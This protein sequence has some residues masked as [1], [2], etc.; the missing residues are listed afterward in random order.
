NSIREKEQMEQ[1]EPLEIIGTGSFGLIRKVRRKT[2]GKILARKEIDYRRMNEK[3]RNQLSAEFSILCE[4]D[5]PNIVRYYGR[6]V[7][8]INCMIYIIM[9][10]C[11]GGDLSSIIK[12]CKK[13]GTF[14]SENTIWHFFTQILRALHECHYGY[15]KNKCGSN[16]SQQHITILHRDIKPDNVFLGS[17]NKLKLGDFG[18]SR[19]LNLDREFAQTYV[20]TPYYMSPELITESHYDVKSDIWSLGCLLYELCA[21]QPPFQAKS[22]PVLAIKISAGTISPIPSRYSDELYNIIKAMLMVDPNQRPTTME[23]IK[24][25]NPNKDTAYREELLKQREVTFEIMVANREEELKRGFAELQQCRQQL[26][27][28]RQQLDFERQQF[29]NDV[30]LHTEQF[31][32]E[33]QRHNEEFKVEYA[34]LLQQK[35]ELNNRFLELK[36]QKELQEQTFQN[37][38]SELK[39]RHDDLQRQIDEINKTRDDKVNDTVQVVAQVEAITSEKTRD[40]KVNDTVQ[41]VTRVEAIT[42]KKTRLRRLIYP[43]L[44]A[45]PKNSTLVSSIIPQKRLQQSSQKSNAWDMDDDDLPSPFIK[46]RRKDPDQSNRGDRSSVTNQEI[47]HAE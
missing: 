15:G 14:L 18:L 33:V 9:E 1:Y 31:N 4:L 32:M 45:R 6:H 21:L 29:T 39:R 34:N 20:G 3:E 47:C 25:L 27:F 43:P 36:R 40:H 2:D 7:D 17:D 13:E 26:D 28:E 19:K 37:Q 12:K 38:E 30:K 35:E 46:Q 41:V 10:Y 11:E 44:E 5:H 23:L 8:K 24:M 22:Q 42:N 16:H